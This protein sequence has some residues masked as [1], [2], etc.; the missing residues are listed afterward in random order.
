[1]TGHIALTAPG[2]RVVIMPARGGK[3]AELSDLERGRD[4]LTSPAGTLDGPLRPGTAFT[5]GDMCGW[6]EMF[7]TIV[8][9][10]YPG[11]CLGPAPELPDH[12]ELWSAAWQVTQ[13]GQRSVLLTVTGAALPYRFARRATVGP[14]SL[15]LDY[16][17]QATGCEPL[18]ALWAAHPQFRSEP[19]TRVVLPAG[20]D[21]V[22]DVTDRARPA[23]IRWLADGGR[24]ADLPHGSGRK[25]YLDPGTRVGWAA[26]ADPGGARLELSWDPALVPYFGIWLDHQQYSREPCV[27]LEP[28]TGFY[29]DLDVAAAGG[30]VMRLLP[31]QSARW[32]VR[33]TLSQ[34]SGTP[35]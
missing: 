32:S 2:I 25:L 35:G 9:C 23:P 10:R 3:I 4:W 5:D 13:T 17:V 16:R 31:G 7:P 8:A 28:A 26:L 11:P 27:C 19:G 30:H 34:D 14:S 12:G 18:D 6:D 15:R 1:M 22:I 33:V 24:V 20:V 21:R 29:D